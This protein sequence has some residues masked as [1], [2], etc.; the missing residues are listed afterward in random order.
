MQEFEY[1]LADIPDVNVDSFEE[2]YK[3]LRVE[4]EKDS[5]ENVVNKES[6]RELFELIR[7]QHDSGNSGLLS[8]GDDL[9]LDNEVSVEG[10][11][12]GRDVDLIDDAVIEDRSNEEERNLVSHVD[13]FD[14]RAE[15]MLNQLKA[16]QENF[17]DAIKPFGNASVS[18]PNSAD[19]DELD[20]LLQGFPAH[21]IEQVREVF[22]MSLGNPSILSLVPTVREVM[23]ERI[24]NS[25]LKKKNITDALAAIESADPDI[26][27]L[28][29]MLQVLSKSG[30]IDKALAFYEKEFKVHDM[31]RNFLFLLS[32]FIRIEA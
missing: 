25:W 23:P 18:L 28:N 8:D 24:S 20:L 2:F 27:I 29:S 30:S 4:F 32:V 9:Q 15:V 21:R 13:D 31:V 3:N 22:T 16:I 6:A 10:D 26:H 11:F 19:T 14:S 17:P 5:E 1:D 7:A 12:R